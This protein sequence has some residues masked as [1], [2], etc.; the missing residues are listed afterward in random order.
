MAR[1]GRVVLAAI[2]DETILSWG[3]INHRVLTWCHS[4]F[5]TSFVH[6]TFFHLF[7]LIK[8]F[9]MTE[10]SMAC[11]LSYEMF[12]AYCLGKRR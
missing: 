11:F 9:M 12:A 4:S 1:G 5:H 2:D 8:S 10:S 6:V 3:E 7:F